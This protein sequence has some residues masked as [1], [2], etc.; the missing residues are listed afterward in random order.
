MKKKGLYKIGKMAIV[1]AFIIV[2]AVFNYEIREIAARNK[3]FFLS[4][5]V[6]PKP[7]FLGEPIPVFGDGRATD[8]K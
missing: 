1:A 8:D 2:I 3:D 4:K 5:F 6:K 7:T